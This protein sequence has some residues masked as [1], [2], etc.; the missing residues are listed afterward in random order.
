MNKAKHAFVL[1]AEIAI[2]VVMTVLLTVINMVNFTMIGDDADH[3]TGVLAESHGVFSS[4]RG[5][6]S[7]KLPSGKRSRQPFSLEG[8]N[9]DDP[10][11]RSSLGYFTVA[12]D[13][14][15]NAEVLVNKLSAV[16]KEEVIEWAQSLRNGTE[17]GWTNTTYRYRV[18]KENGVR[19]VTVIDQSRELGSVYRILIVSIVGGLLMVLICLFL[20][21]R[22][23]TKVFAPLEESDRRQKRFIQQ[24]ESEFKLPLTII[25]ANTELLERK[26]GP[27]EE[28]AVINKQVRRMTELVRELGAL[29]IFE[30][31]AGPASI[32]DL[33]GLFSAAVDSRRKAFE[34]AGLEVKTDIQPTVTI[35]G[36]AQALR[37]MAEELVDNG[38]QFAKGSM[39]LSLKATNG[40]ITILQSN[41]TDLKD[42]SADHVFDRFVTLENAGKGCGLGLAYVKE[43]VKAH[44]GRVKAS[45][46]KGVFTLQ[47]DL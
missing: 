31:E 19:Y 46:S 2:L 29:T 42:G 41:P 21:Q 9:P 35:K 1:Y 11:L 33:S 37:R 47:I 43:A 24:A 40:R 34:E 28:T 45:V 32:V 23:G 15:G 5:S 13:K 18:Y 12:F 27:T 38:C 20:L 6:T 14:E 4:D 16:Q 39:E 3:L 44:N 10:E 17:T 8:M 25:N 30:E 7:A 22:V 36:D 26:N